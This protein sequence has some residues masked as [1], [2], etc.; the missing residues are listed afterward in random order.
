[1]ILFIGFKPNTLTAQVVSDTVNPKG[2]WFFGAEIGSNKINSFS[3]GEPNK[4]I[5]AGLLAEYYFARH[6]SLSGRIKYFETGV[7]FY[8]PNTHSSSWFDL[9]SDESYG[10]FNGAVIAAPIAIKWEFRIYKNLKANLKIG[11]AYNFETKS[12]YYFSPNLETNNSKIFV[13]FNPGFGFNYFLSEKTAIYFDI[14][15]YKFG[16]YKGNSQSQI[17]SKNYYTENNL[18]NL[19]IKYTF[20]K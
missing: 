14:E 18:I 16:G 8:K 11:G 6:W 4:S 2:K 9:G 10:F 17:L 13:N 1:M 12:N 5:Q 15:T 3:L 7:S 20:K 19:G